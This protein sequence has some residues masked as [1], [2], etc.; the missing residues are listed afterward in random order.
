MAN[1]SNCPLWQDR[2]RPA[3]RHPF[4]LKLYPETNTHTVHAPFPLVKPDSQPPKFANKRRGLVG[5]VVSEK[6]NVLAEVGL[7]IRRGFA[8][9][10]KVSPLRC[11]MPLH[12]PHGETEKTLTHGIADAF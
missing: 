1:S 6:L 2:P 3:L 8:G 7:Q 11:R 10:K 9:G 4:E 12:S 5:E